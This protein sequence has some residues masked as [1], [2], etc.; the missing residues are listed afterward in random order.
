VFVLA[1]LLLLGLS[2]CRVVSTEIPLP[3]PTPLGTPTPTAPE[4][5]EL[6]TTPLLSPTYR[7]GPEVPGE[8]RT[9]IREAVEHA[10]E[11]FVLPHAPGVRY[12]AEVLA[13]ADYGRLVRA[14]AEENSIPEL[15][16]RR[17][18]DRGF[19]AVTLVEKIFLF[20][21]RTFDQA[22]SSE[23]AKDVEHEAFHVVQQK[24]SNRISPTDP[25]WVSGP[26]WLFEGS[27]EYAG[28]WAVA[29]RGMWALE[30]ELAA[31]RE[32]AA[33]AE[34]P[35][36]RLSFSH[37]PTDEYDVAAVAVDL[38]LDSGGPLKLMRFYKRLGTVSV[39]GG[40]WQPSFRRVF[41]RSPQAFYREFEAARA[42]GF[43]D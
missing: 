34:T 9:F 22:P 8:Q 28:I 6:V 14:Y 17:E 43:P 24:L 36:P 7:F 16:A 11:V 41:D 10:N 12:D 13:F 19:A 32:I 2:G 40:P 18:W 25:A 31:R 4:P 42:R 35:L 21:P 15:A 3:S 1:L 20:T 26:L 38:L 39:D 23:W 30:Q 5:G 27:A 33:G 29:E 37:A